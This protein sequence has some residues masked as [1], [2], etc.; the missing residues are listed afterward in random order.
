MRNISDTMKPDEEVPKKGNLSPKLRKTLYVVLAAVLAIS[1][2]I[3]VF[4]QS[5]QAYAGTTGGDTSYYSLYDANQSYSNISVLRVD[6]NAAYCVEFD[7]AFAVGISVAGTNAV[8]VYGQANVTKFALLKDYIYSVSWLNDTQRYFISQ[9]LVW[10]ELNPGRFPSGG[11]IIDCGVSTQNQINLKAEARAYYE[12]NKNKFIGGGTY[13]SAGAAQDLAEFW[14]ERRAVGSIT[15]VKES[16]NHEATDGNSRYSLAGAIYTIYNTSNQAVGT[17]TVDENGKCNTVSNLWVD[18]YYVKETKAPPGYEKNTTTYTANIASDGQVITVQAKDEPILGLLELQKSSAN[19]SIT[20]GNDCY[21]LN[22]AVYGVYRSE[23]NA[24]TDTNRYREIT[25]NNA[26]YASADKMPLGEYWVCEVKAPEG[27]AIDE[28]I[29][30]VDIS[31]QRTKVSVASK[32]QPKNDPIGILLN[33]IDADTGLEY[34]GSDKAS[35]EGAEFTVH[36]YD[37][38][39]ATVA[40]TLSVEPTRTWIIKTDDEG[41]ALFA[42]E[43]LVGGDAL[44]KNSA[45]DATIPIGTFTVQ[46]TKAPEGYLLSTPTLPNDT[47]IFH[48]TD[49]GTDGEFLYVYNAQIVR[50]QIVRGDIEIVKYQEDE[51]ATPDMP[52]ELKTPEVGVTFDL[53]ASRD[54][55]GTTPNDGAVPAFSMVTDEDGVASTIDTGECLLEWPDGS[56]TTRPRTAND[57]G[58]L[59]YDTYLVVQRD[60]PYGYSPANSFTV[61][62]TQDKACR[63]YIVGNVLIASAIRVEKVDSETGVAV[64]YEAK[65]QILD[66]ETLEPV[67]MTLRYP[68]TEVLDTFVSNNE[69]WLMLPEMLPAGNYLLHEVEAPNNGKI[70]YLINPVDI[71]FEVT[72]YHDWDNPLVVTC[73]DNPAKG[74]IEFIKFDALEG[75]GVVGATY[76]VYA[77]EDIYTLDGTLRA[78]EGDEVARFVTDESGYAIT[79]ALYLGNYYVVEIATPDGFA[80]NPERYPVELVYQ[81]QYATAYSEYAEGE[82][83]PT[84]LKI[85]K[86]DATTGEPLAGFSF[87]IEDSEGNVTE[88]VTGEDGYC[89]YPYLPQG[90]YTVYETAT[91]P[92]YLLSDEMI[93]I[94]VDENGLIEGEATFEI[95]FANDYTKVVIGKTDIVTGE[96]VIGATLQIFP[97]DEEGNLSEEPL[98]EWVTTEE[99]YLIERMAEGNYILREFIA[100]AGYLV[101]QDIEFTVEATGEI[102]R[103]EMQDDFTRVEIVKVDASTGKPLAGA[104]LQLIDSEGNIVLEWETTEEPVV[105]DRLP[106]GKYTLHEVSAPEGYELAKDIT[107]TVTDSADT[108]TVTMADE[109][110]KE[111]ETPKESLDKT[112]RDNTGNLIFLGIIALIGVGGTCYAAWHL[113]RKKGSDE[114]SP[115][116]E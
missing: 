38:Q 87:A 63:T 21:R 66:A 9:A 109:K 25:T 92:G 102:Q 47:R 6:G 30:Y 46:E 114:D 70:G 62:V 57:S 10:E 3:A 112:G 64:S 106:Q 56:Y 55:T 7:N 99:D 53:Y 8:N 113:R 104:V 69:G 110:V 34:A 90:S 35:L 95:I 105:M 13:W 101:A 29:Y 103:H 1:S 49:D 31:T 37:A 14:I 15:L 93:E 42:D 80:L 39:L 52:S 54:F 76:A 40:D 2:V 41:Y 11:L 82:D 26:G 81:D 67:S 18:T 84:T 27:Y 48:I 73:A 98:H 78:S 60:A 89:A 32:D 108:L 94:V 50:E 4:A 22:G 59:P 74:Y 20:D 43:Y 96:P 45:G 68:A 5:N 16:A 28:T 72:E 44:Y 36:Y 61:N 65:W 86:L 19:A 17:L 100:P 71:A 51:V 91:A 12:Q 33:K 111:P 85:L 107:F 75:L 23:A 97:V 88:L 115:E 79:D 116:N 24:A 83:Q 58:A 77:A